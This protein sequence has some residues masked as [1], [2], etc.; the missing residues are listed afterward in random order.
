MGEQRRVE[1]ELGHFLS[2]SWTGLEWKEALRSR[3]SL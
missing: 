1:E 2:R 3:M